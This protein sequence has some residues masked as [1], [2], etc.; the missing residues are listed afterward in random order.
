MNWRVLRWTL[1]AVAVIS[2]LVAFVVW[3]RNRPAR[4]G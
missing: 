2:E 3:R 1:V 4:P